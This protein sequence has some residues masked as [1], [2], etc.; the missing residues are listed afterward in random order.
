MA[1]LL[2]AACSPTKLLGTVAPVAPGGEV[3]DVAYGNGA[4]EN[5]DIYA[6]DANSLSAPVVVFFYGGG[7]TSGERAM[8]RFIGRG[9]AA[10]GV[11][12]MIPDYRIWPETGFPGF[13][14]DAAAAVARAR[15][16]APAHG[17]DPKRVFLMGHSAGAYIAAMLTL[18]PQ[19][20]AAAGVDSRTALAGMVGIAG[21]YD[22]LPLRDPVLKEIFGAAGPDTQPISFAK[23]ATA[24][25]L[26]LTGAAD[27]TVDPANSQHLAARVRAAG[28][29]AESIIYPG[30]GH[31]TV[32]G[33]FA[34]PLRFLGPVRD[35]ACRFFGAPHQTAEPG[36]APNTSPAGPHLG[37]KGQVNRTTKLMAGELQTPNRKMPSTAWPAARNRESDG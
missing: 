19:W 13:L 31:A 35:D 30:L 23:N 8:Y 27:L 18:D 10:C 4:R 37:P 14:R 29:Q 20:L 17:G 22:F 9:L 1:T 26:L 7:W 36:A 3:T 28:R 2:S 6:P 33:A 16:V 34:G 11:V 21:P 24:P 12:A 5:M 32:L 25:L 15:M